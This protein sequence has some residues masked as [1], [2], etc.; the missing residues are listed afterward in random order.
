MATQTK[1]ELKD[2]LIQNNFINEKIN[3]DVDYDIL[4][5]Y[6]LYKNYLFKKSQFP[7]V[8]TAILYLRQQMGITTDINEPYYEKMKKFD[9]TIFEGTEYLTDINEL[10]KITK[11]IGILSILSINDKEF[12]NTTKGVIIQKIANY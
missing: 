4:E 1:A 2:S 11:N 8:L 9:K 3:Q 10:H 7:N 12:D 6:P 5:K